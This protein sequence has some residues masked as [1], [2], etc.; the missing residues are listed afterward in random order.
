MA[1]LLVNLTTLKKGKENYWR[2][3]LMLMQSQSVF[4]HMALSLVDELWG[5]IIAKLAS[6]SS[7]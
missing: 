5:T 2:T 6:P 1:L 4:E 3:Q 7:S